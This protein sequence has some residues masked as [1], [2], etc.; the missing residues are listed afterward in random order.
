MQKI[1][2][3]LRLSIKLEK[4]GKSQR[5][6]MFL[7]ALLKSRVAVFYGGFSIRKREG[8]RPSRLFRHEKTRLGPFT[9]DICIQYCARG[10]S[11]ARTAGGLALETN[12]RY[13]G[14]KPK[15][16]V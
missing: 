12:G 16:A 8:E 14:R 3:N 5:R 11:G 4:T 2:D 6:Q 9:S 10:S 13:I 7:I 1:F 15:Q